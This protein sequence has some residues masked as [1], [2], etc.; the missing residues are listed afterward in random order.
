MQIEQHQIKMKL[1]KFGYGPLWGLIDLAVIDLALEVCLVNPAEA[2]LSAAWLNDRFG[3]LLP[4]P[5]KPF[6][7]DLIVKVWL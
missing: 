1:P 3:L 6:R 7:L 4:L 5:L 2:G